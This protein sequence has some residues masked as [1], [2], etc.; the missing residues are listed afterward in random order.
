M[1]AKRTDLDQRSQQ[2]MREYLFDAALV[3]AANILIGRTVIGFG[4]SNTR[5]CALNGPIMVPRQ[6]G[7]TLSYRHMTEGDVAPDALI[8]LLESLGLG[9]ELDDP[10]VS[11][12]KP[13][14][15]L[16]TEL[17]QRQAVEKTRYNELLAT[18]RLLGQVLA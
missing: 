9:D 1:Y 16:H 14:L 10:R 18:Y 4:L 15:R 13:R 12:E 7:L 8:E 3:V 5:D 17:T 2:V 6:D 11:D